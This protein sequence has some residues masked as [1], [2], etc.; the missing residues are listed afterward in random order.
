MLIPYTNSL[1]TILMINSDED[2]LGVDLISVH[3]LHHPPWGWVPFLFFSSIFV[4]P[5]T[6]LDRDRHSTYIYWMLKNWPDAEFQEKLKLR[7]HLSRKKNPTSSQKNT[8]DLILMFSQRQNLWVQAKF[9]EYSIQDSIKKTW[10][11]FF[12]RLI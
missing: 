12:A 10:F 9:T 3:I 11:L 4:A 7:E 6:R 2:Y 8:P 1:Q 5:S